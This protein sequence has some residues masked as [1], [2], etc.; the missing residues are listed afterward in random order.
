MLSAPRLYALASIV[1]VS[2]ALGGCFG[3]EGDPAPTACDFNG[4]QLAIGETV[5]H[6]DGCNSCTCW[7]DYVLECSTR[8]CEDDGP[9]DIED[10]PPVVEDRPPAFLDVGPAPVVDVGL[11][12][13]LDAGP[14]PV[15]DAGPALWPPPL[16]SSDEGPPAMD[17]GPPAIVDAGPAPVV[18][19][20]P[21]DRPPSL[22]RD[23]D[24]DGFFTCV[25]LVYPERPAAVDCDDTRFFV[26]PGGY[27][28]PNNAVDD[29]CDGDID[30]TAPCVCNVGSTTP[31]D[32]TGAIGLCGDTLTSARKSG[33]DSQ[34]GVMTSYFDDV[35]PIDAEEGVAPP[36]SCLAVLSTGDALDDFNLSVSHIGLPQCSFPDPEPNPG[37]RDG[38][39][40]FDL[41]QLHLK[42]KAPKNAQGFQFHFMFLSAEW[43]EFLCQVFNDTFFA[44]VDLEATGGNRL[45]IAKDPQGRRISVNVGFF[46]AP[47]EWTTP[48]GN[49]PYGR[50]ESS[51]TARCNE[52]PADPSCRLPEYCTTSP[53]ADLAYTG[54][55]SG[56]LRASAPVRPGEEDI[57]ITLSISDKSDS[58]LDSLV[59]LDGFVWT[60]E[61]PPLGTLK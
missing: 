45:N 59:I 37:L 24:L 10:R 54:S 2:A 7:V 57:E 28:F 48:L 22:C 43:P 46:E 58:G 16:C 42:L 50:V 44:V 31:Q 3:T 29:D 55:G 11:P 8:L 18:D 34:F 49:T 27:E 51:L 5:A 25:D 19:A 17:D 13:L 39:P 26:Q 56:W 61:A 15:V 23:D 35:R 60:P 12:V 47:R 6:P 14:V 1:S 38:F 30:E 21:V 20:G 4:R 9:R 40:N 52:I 41:A 33:V 36:P 53:A 32:I